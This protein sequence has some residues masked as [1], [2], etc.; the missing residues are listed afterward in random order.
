MAS[1]SDILVKGE[2]AP[3]FMALLVSALKP[4]SSSP[5]LTAVNF[6]TERLFMRARSELAVK[7][8]CSIS[9]DE[10]VGSAWELKGGSRV[11]AVFKIAGGTAPG[12]V[13]SVPGDNDLEYSLRRLL[14]NAY[15]PL[16]RLADGTNRLSPLYAGYVREIIADCFPV[17]PY[18]DEA[19]ECACSTE[20]VGRVGFGAKFC[21][22]LILFFIPLLSLLW[23]MFSGKFF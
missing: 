3:L 4:G 13:I 12:L 17:L 11:L 8:S 16:E 23:K 9:S 15:T 22:F 7:A 2:K 14:C 1:Q 21:L 10:A 19:K 20:A 6:E 18:D 5:C